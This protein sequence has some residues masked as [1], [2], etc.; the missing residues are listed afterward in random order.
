MRTLSQAQAVFGRAGIRNQV[1]S[2]SLSWALVS[3]EASRRETWPPPCPLPTPLHSHPSHKHRTILKIERSFPCS[4]IIRTSMSRGNV[5][6][7][8]IPTPTFLQ[9]HPVFLNSHIS[10]LALPPISRPTLLFPA[11]KRSLLTAVRSRAQKV[12]SG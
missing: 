1:F 9:D 4:S 5:I 2:F 7:P 6:K 3:A 10:E 11:E 8:P 12:S